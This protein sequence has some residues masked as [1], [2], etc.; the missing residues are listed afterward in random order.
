M[1][2]AL[3]SVCLFQSSFENRKHRMDFTH[4]KFAQFILGQTDNVR[5]GQIE[6]T[7]KW[8]FVF[9]DG[10]RLPGPGEMHLLVSPGQDICRQGPEEA[11]TTSSLSRHPITDHSSRRAPLTHHTL[12]TKNVQNYTNIRRVCGEVE[13]LHHSLL[14]DDICFCWLLTS[15]KISS[16]LSL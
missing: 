5:S 16:R 4:S 11:V 8:V 7:C 1:K 15:G 12:V 2:K 9:R 13:I 3:F 14:Q 6:S 10:R